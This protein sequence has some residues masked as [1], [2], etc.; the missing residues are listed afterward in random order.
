MILVTGGTGLVGSHLLYHL[1]Q[2]EEKIRAVHRSGSDL[3]KVKKV[4]GYYTSQPET[5]FNKIEWVEASLNDITELE[6]VFDQITRVYHCAAVVSFDPKDYH[7][8]RKVN[9][10]GTENIVNLSILNKIEKL[11]FVSSIATLSKSV[12]GK[13]ITEENYW[14]NAAGKSGYAITKQGA[15]TEVWRAGQEGIDV[16]IVNPGVI[17]GSGFWEKGT[18]KLFDKI[19]RGFKYYT[20]GVTGFI[21]V[22]DVAKI[23]IL[24]M[25]SDIKNE[26][27]ILV[28]E[29]RSFKD[30]FF[31]IADHLGVKRPS[32]KVSS[33]LSEMGWKL[34]WLKGKVLNKAPDLTKYSARAGLQKKYYSSEKIKNTLDYSFEPLEKTIETTC[35]IYLKE[36]TLP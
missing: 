21:G 26:R 2:Q 6:K 9:I 16:V 29:N 31:L 8:M 27:F 13:E 34:A 10:E 15:E 35:K 20:T 33:F 1:A 17:L 28:A 12:N 4:F 25:K 3:Q 18:G 24:L 7:I 23:M 11:C 36:F 30:V 14:T 32:T 5:L 19:Y 22:T